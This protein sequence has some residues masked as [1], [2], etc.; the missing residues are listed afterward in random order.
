LATQELTAGGTP[1]GVPTSAAEDP[2]LALADEAAPPP[3]ERG[4]NQWV[5]TLLSFAIVFGA[6]EIA[7]RI[8][9]SFSFP[10][11]TA[12][13]SALVEMLLDGSMIHAYA[14]TLQPLVI[15]VALCAVMAVVFGVGMGLSR[16]LEWFSLPIFIIVQAAPMAA[17]IPLITF[18]YGIGL[19][20]KVLAVVILSAPVI[21]LNSYKGIRNTNPSLVEM[22]RS[23]LASRTQQIVKV[24]IPAASGLIFAGLRLGV[25]AGFTGA[26]LAEL[27]ITP[28]GVGDLI[29]YHRSVAEY[30][31]MFATIFSIIIFASV[32]VTLLQRLEIA[33]FRRDQ[34]EE[35]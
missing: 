19:A 14:I 16:T 10:P 1:A 30:D 20:S 9:I 32:S 15:G 12:T 7:G 5:W 26:V 2:H 28:T 29:T 21:V 24:I 35:R 25:A 13:V 23:F 11:F 3:Q 4:G 18:V 34:R 31:K 8:P 17:F 33:L 27:L 22:S 6:W